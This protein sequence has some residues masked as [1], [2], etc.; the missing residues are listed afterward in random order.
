MPYFLISILCSLCYSAFGKSWKNLELG[1]TYRLTQSF[2]LRQ[3]ERSGSQIF[4]VTGDD[5][6]LK[7]IIPKEISGPSRRLYVFDLKKCPGRDMKTEMD[8]IS[9]KDTSPTVEI[10]AQL[11]DCELNIYLGSKDL[12]HTSLFE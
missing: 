7:E 2:K 8:I 3:I 9:I 5:Y 1:Q 11:D 4:F 6:H 12:I 10:S